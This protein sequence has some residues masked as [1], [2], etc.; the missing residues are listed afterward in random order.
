MASHTRI[1]AIPDYHGGDDVLVVK[2]DMNGTIVWE[3]LFGGSGDDF[4]DN[5]LP[6]ADGGYIGIGYTN[7]NDGD[8]SGNHGSYDAWLFRLDESGNLL[9]QRCLGGTLFDEGREIVIAPGGEYAVMGSTNSKDGD[10][11]AGTMDRST[12]GG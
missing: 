12:T 6:V 10:V 11:P 1:L 4:G 2:S 5:I 7:S 8:V 3:K 9:W